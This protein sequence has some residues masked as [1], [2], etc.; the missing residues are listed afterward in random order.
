MDLVCVMSGRAVHD[1]QAKVRVDGITYV[2]NH[3]AEYLDAGQ[4]SVASGAAEYRD[5]IKRVLDHLRKVVALPG[6]VWDDKHY[7][8]SVHYRLAA[9]AGDARR[10]LQDALDSAPGAGDLEVFWGKMVLEIRAPVGIDKGYAVRKLVGERQLG[11]IVVMGD[12]ITDLDALAALRELRASSDLRGHGVVVVH[13]DS[14]E[15]LARV[16]DYRLN[17]VGEVEVFLEWLAAA[18]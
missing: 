11:G 4:A 16:A 10:M 1:L 6:L 13:E 14:P 18:K 3:G 7:S 5:K 8:A 15:E 2:G 17:G 12:D 9:D